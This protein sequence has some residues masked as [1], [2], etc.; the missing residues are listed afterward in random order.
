MT[1]VLLAY[2]TAA[3]WSSNDESTPAGGVPMDDNYSPEDIAPD[4]LAQMAQDLTSFITAN[5]ADIAKGCTR[6]RDAGTS[7]YHS[8]EE[9]AAH[10][11]WL[12]RNGHGAGFWDGDWEDTP[13]IRGDLN[14][15]P[16]AR[17]NRLSAAAH[18]FGSFDLYVGDDGL[19]H[20]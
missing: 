2:I 3:L 1:P 4:T 8:A 20:A 6:S 17:A 18:A 16:E 13:D 11:F 19:I 10:D 12:T 15:D 14:F 5:A 9:M 7:I